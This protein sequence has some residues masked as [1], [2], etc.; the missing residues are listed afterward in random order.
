MTHQHAVPGRSR[1]ETRSRLRRAH[2]HTRSRQAR[3]RSRRS[4]PPPWGRDRPPPCATDSVRGHPACQAQLPAA[5]CCATHAPLPAGQREAWR[6]KLRLS[7]LPLV[8]Q[9]GARPARW[10]GACTWRTGR[11]PRS[12]M[13]PCCRTW[14]VTPLLSHSPGERAA[15]WPLQQGSPVGRGHIAVPAVVRHGSALVG[16]GV[17]V[18]PALVAAPV[19]APVIGSLPALCPV[20]PVVAPVAVPTALG[21]DMRG[22]KDLPDAR[23]ATRACARQQALE[24]RHCWLP[25]SRRPGWRGGQGRRASLR[26]GAR[27]WRRGC[28][29]LSGTGEWPW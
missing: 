22:C 6:I 13:R 5:G 16:V 4:R 15:C 1:L 25:V 14:A 20:G 17:W 28:R 18:A 19:V 11:V 9:R 26:R 3:A 8:Q 24:A 12:R 21:S 7:G 10:Q 29:G 27:S 2:G 23:A